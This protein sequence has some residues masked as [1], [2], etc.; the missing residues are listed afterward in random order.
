MNFSRHAQIRAR[1]RGIDELTVEILN[2][3][4]MDSTAGDGC[5]VRSINERKF[6]EMINAIQKAKNK[7]LIIGSDNTVISI[8]HNTKKRREKY[9]K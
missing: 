8:Q 2:F 1:Q 4:G 5:V 6:K 7:S 9:G 3:F